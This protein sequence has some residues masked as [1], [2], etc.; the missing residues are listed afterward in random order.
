MYLKSL[1]LFGFKSFPSKTVLRFGPGIT[2]V[3]GPNGCGKSN[4]FDA[5]KWALGEQSPKSLRGTKMEDV[6]FNGTATTPPLNYAEV[7]LIFS[8]ED[9]YLPIEYK[10]V[11]VTRRLYRSGESQYFINRNLC[12]L[13]DIQDLFMGTGIGEYTYSFIEQ[14]R[15]EMLLSYKPEEKRLIF[16]EASGIIKYKDKKKETLR[17]LKDT[18]ENILRLDDIILEV[19]RQMNYLERQVEKAKKYNEIRQ[20]LIDVEKNIA[21]MKTKELD[22]RIGALSNEIEH[23]K[24]KEKE[25]EENILQKSTDRDSI[26]REINQLRNG[27][28]EINSETVSYNSRI[29]GYLNHITINRQRIEEIKERLA[30]LNNSEKE[31]KERIALHKKRIEEGKDSLG[32]LD[33]QSQRLQEELANLIRLKEDRVIKIKDAKKDIAHKKELILQLEEKKT[34]L[35]NSLIELETHAKNILARK[36]RLTLDEA[37]I[38]NYLE[39]HKQQLA[40]LEEILKTLENEFASLKENKSRL[41]RQLKEVNEQIE[42]QEQK[43]LEI[44]KTLVE[45]RS[46]F[47]FLKDLKIKYDDF[48]LKKKVTLVFDEDPRD[49]NKLI[50]SLKGVEFR[51]IEFEGSYRYRAEIEAKIISLPEEELARRINLLIKEEEE[52]KRSIEENKNTAQKIVSQIE[53]GENIITE[54]DNNLRDYLQRKDNLVE[55]ISRLEEEKIL[56]EDELKEVTTEISSVEDRQKSIKEELSLVESRLD[57]TI[58]DLESSQNNTVVFGEEVNKFEIEIAKKDTEIKALQEQKESILTK[59]S[60]FEEEHARI[61]ERIV[62]LDKEKRSL[63]DRKVNLNGEIL[64]LEKKIKEAREK[65][66]V[67]NER[68]KEEEERLKELEDSFTLLQEA[69]KQEENI[70]EEIRNKIYNKRLET[71]KINFEKA[72][73]VDYLKQV[74]NV[75][76]ILEE[77]SSNIPLSDL[78]TE[79][80]KLKKRIDS[81]GEVNLVAIDEAKEL[82][83]RYQ[84]LTTQKEDL[85][86]SKESLKKAIQKINRTSKEVFLETFNKIEEEFKKYF[87]FLFGGGR[88][89]LV[90]LDKENILE[91]GVEIEVQPPGKKLQSV[92]LLSGGE[93]ALTAI[94]L[95]FSIFKVKPSPLCVLDEIDAPLDE[96]NVDRFNQLLVEFSPTSQFIVIT[97]NKKTMSRADVLYGV[98]MEERG[99]SKLVSVRFAQEETSPVK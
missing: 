94:A 64:E 84:F 6:I 43:L 40:S 55:S 2:V 32:S 63:E 7:T 85:L 15:V 98:T 41:R 26:D 33:S 20:R 87:R 88:A 5:I 69:L 66:V 45:L 8:N 22:G 31:S 4:V 11:A 77:V 58:R 9:N 70:L 65:I 49:I 39:E 51:R 89:Q 30:I 56:I 1:E 25:K 35:N 74:Y 23:L 18:E 61:E 60:L 21:A 83:E 14:G 79:R 47:E 92:S 76:F 71:Q 68:K 42:Q 57:S 50:A 38:N 62:S 27:I 36:K 90:L 95:I 80:D 72:K 44:E 48:P 73:I 17:K 93:K 13:K 34:T 67:L 37:R 19:K 96:A 52:L 78:E 24:K 10:E 3:V 59:L 16:D 99:I 12:R 86:S 97:H 28:S 91:S 54:K 29:E 46:Y 53:E 81:L 75:E 82:N